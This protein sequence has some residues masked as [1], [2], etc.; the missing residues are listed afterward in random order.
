M[1]IGIDVWM[2]IGDI[3]NMMR[4]WVQATGC[5]GS[6]LLSRLREKNIVADCG[7]VPRPRSK[8]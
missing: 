6:K 5:L 1:G 7:I 2:D 4:L 3:V 8:R